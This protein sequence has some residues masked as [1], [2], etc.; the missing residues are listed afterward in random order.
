MDDSIAVCVI[1][2]YSHS[3][4]ILWDCTCNILLCYKLCWHWGCFTSDW[5]HWLT[6]SLFWRYWTG[7][8]I[9][10]QI[11][12]FPFWHNVSTILDKYLEH[13]TSM[14]SINHVHKDYSWSWVE[15]SWVRFICFSLVQS[16]GSIWPVQATIVSRI[17]KE[18]IWKNYR[19]V[20][21]KQLDWNQDFC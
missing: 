20:H 17:F 8:I 3:P 6:V 15:L 7:L 14:T 19:T 13:Q 5:N 2:K 10:S 9:P 1:Q 21:K 4:Y 12:W 18:N 11:I 16:S